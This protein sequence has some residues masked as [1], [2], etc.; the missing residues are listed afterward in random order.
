MGRQHIRRIAGFALVIPYGGVVGFV[1][2]NL[3]PDRHERMVEVDVSVRA[4]PDYP[5]GLP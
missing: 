1:V 4:E 5:R 2:Q 3:G